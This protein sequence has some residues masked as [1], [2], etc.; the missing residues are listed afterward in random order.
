MR[1]EMRGVLNGSARLS[2]HCVDLIVDP[3]ELGAP[4]SGNGAGK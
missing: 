2:L 1:R 4:V 3:R